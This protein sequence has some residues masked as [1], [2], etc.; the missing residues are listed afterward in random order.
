MNETRPIKATKPS[1]LSFE[2]NYQLLIPYAAPYFV[3]VAVGAL[4]GSIPIEWIYGFRLVV[5]PA[6]LVWAWRWYVPI[7]G[8]KSQWVSIGMGILVG[9]LGT[10]IWIGLMAP[11]AP[12]E[13]N[14]WGQQAFCLRTAASTLIVPVFEELL[15][16]G[17]VFRLALQWDLERKKGTGAALDKTLNELRICDIETLSWSI[18]AIVISTVVFTLGHQMVEWPAAIAYGA[19]MAIL[20]I[21][22]K[23]LLSC[24]TAHVV[25]NFCLAMYVGATG[26]WQYW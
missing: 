7:G 15:M 10:A 21:V 11:F 14:A 1:T 4:Q 22:R 5:V 9:V 24:M 13:A 23:D 6:I 12:T 19:L 25:T 2:T 18:P 3:Y 17:Y 8:P 16:R 26:S 20:L